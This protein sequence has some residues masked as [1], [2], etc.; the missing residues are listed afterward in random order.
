M[1]DETS[2]RLLQQLASISSDAMRQPVDWEARPDTAVTGTDATGNV[3]VELR[4]FDVTGVRIRPGWLETA[5]RAALETAVQQAVQDALTGLVDAELERAR[6][7]SYD[8][9]DVHTRLLQLSQEASTAMN[10]RIRGLGEGL[11]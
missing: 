9:A 8:Q 7:T 6:T 10:D 1:G 3:N 5:E 4:G 2:A 11:R